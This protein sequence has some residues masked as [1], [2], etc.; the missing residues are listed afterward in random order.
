MPARKPVRRSQLISPFGVG[1]ITNFPGDESLMTAGL[2]AWP[3]ALEDCPL[4]W[5][6]K[7]ERL[8]SRLRVDH[9]RLPPEHRDPGPGVDN[10]N[11]NIPYLR[12]PRWHYC[13]RCGFMQHAP[14]FQLQANRCPGRPFGQGMDCSTLPERRR[15]HL[16][17]VRILAACAKGHAQDFPFVEWVHQDA[18]FT[19]N[20]TLRFRA[21]RSSAS[22][23]GIKI[24]CTCGQERSL[25]GVFS[26]G[27][28]HG[29]G[30]DCRGDQPWLG[31][32]SERH[33]GCGEYLRVVQRGASNV[34][35]PHV[36][37]SIYL[38]LWGENTERPIVKTLENS[39][40]WAALTDG[41][42]EGKYIDPAKAGA[43]AMMLGLD[44]EELRAAAQRKL[45][46]AASED[47]LPTE[48]EY[49]RQEYNAL[50]EGR[51]G[52]NT[53]LFVEVKD[54]K[55]YDPRIAEIFSRICLVRKL[56]ETRALV[57]FSR[58]LPPEGDSQSER[59]RPLKVNSLINWLPAMMVRGEGIFF[60]FDPSKV[61]EWT[62]IV[63]RPGT[64]IRAL[65]EAYGR[66]RHERSQEPREIT[67][68]FVMMHTFA[69]MLINQLAFDCG[70]GSASLR[71]RLYCDFEEG[72]EPMQG[73]LIYTASGDSEGT[74]GG[75]VRQG[76]PDRL[77]DTIERAVRKAQWCSSDPVCI[78]STGQGTD[79]AN[80]AACHACVLI[81]ETSCEE[82]NRL[83]DRATVVG[84]P[85]DPGAGF[86]QRM[87]TEV[88]VW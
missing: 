11:Q 46:G 65:L 83:L 87:A 73:V 25:A 8:Q 4:D 80:L 15:P 24:T 37:S 2:D 75:L 54:P 55:D 56:R 81:S 32:E 60:E 85:D 36:I 43:V 47:E 39:R 72:S 57:G 68:K 26:E 84:T 31:R 16:I 19:G 86:F 76:E 62:E 61:K 58:L 79:N 20:C 51:G 41:L 27:R 38:P 12:F 63:D 23:A 28:L 21:G 78:E 18:P 17:P 59:L 82:G 5:L 33:N 45:D 52:A 7:E 69:H 3:F 66:S 70:Y 77:P 42:V 30:Q 74:M 64:R 1:A 10:P 53:E 50:R 22:L 34:Y 49:R 35:F 48:E 40:F 6:V 67:P 29:I 44:A 14:L 88:A 9:F 71:E 13:H